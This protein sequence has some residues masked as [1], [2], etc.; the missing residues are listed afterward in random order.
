MGRFFNVWVIRQKIAQGLSFLL[1]CH[2]CRPICYAA[3]K[4]IQFSRTYARK[5]SKRP[6]NH[7]I[8]ARSLCGFPLSS[9]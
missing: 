8:L 4:S 2:P 9:Q 7:T 3:S 1:A 5:C 6:P